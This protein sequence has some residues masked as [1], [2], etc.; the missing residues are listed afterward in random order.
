[1][2]EEMPKISEQELNELRFIQ[3]ISILTN[4]GIQQLGGTD[5]EEH[6][7]MSHS[8]HA[9]V[10]VGSADAGKRHGGEKNRETCPD[11]LHESVGEVFV[12]LQRR[13]GKAEDDHDVASLVMQF[14]GPIQGC[15]IGHCKI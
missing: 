7:G 8:Q 3:Y 10:A 1:M 15:I 13:A 12:H 11:H 14:F 4:S 9:V 2:S 6:F 5:A